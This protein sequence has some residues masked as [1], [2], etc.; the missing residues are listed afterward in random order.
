MIEKDIRSGPV[1]DNDGKLLGLLTESDMLWKGAG[2]PEDHF[3][4]PPIFIGAFDLFFYLKD[5]KAVK[6]E[7][8]KILARKVWLITI[9][10][11]EDVVQA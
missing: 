6:A 9:G 2:V 11:A 7:V 4:V 1:I 3:L 8:K 5:D 10:I